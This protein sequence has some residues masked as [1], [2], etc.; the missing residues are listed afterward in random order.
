MSDGIRLVVCDLDGTLLAS[1]KRVTPHTAAAIRRAR[2]AGVAV[3]VCSGRIHAMMAG[4]LR[5]IGVEGPYIAANGAVV[6]DAGSGRLVW[7]AP[8]PGE[9]A[10]AVM[11]KAA[12]DGYDVG[13]LGTMGC[14]FLRKSV[15]MERFLAYNR[16]ME[17]KGVLGVA[18]KLLAANEPLPEEVYKLLVCEEDDERRQSMMEF[19][20]DRPTL[21]CTSSEP[22]LLDVSVRGVDKGTGLRRLMELTGLKRE[23]V[24][25]FGDYL[26]DLPMLREA[27]F[28]V[29]MSNGCAELKAVADMVAPGNDE[30]GV[31]QIIERYIV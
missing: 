11:E 25:A 10:A 21:N 29:A 3:T 13:A 20:A 26:N 6:A 5:D 30:D 12:A 23:Q 4:Y 14:Y 17:P 18:C 19:I 27:G 22:M 24:C 7:G 31:A 16:I 1:D 15:C 9:D 8:I 2:E 28:A